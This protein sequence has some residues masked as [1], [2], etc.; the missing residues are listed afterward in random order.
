MIKVDKL[1][2]RECL[3]EVL[4]EMFGTDSVSKVV[5]AE[6]LTLIVDSKMIEVDLN[7]MVR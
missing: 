7:T 1:H 5:K 4:S 3:S 6:T 2:F